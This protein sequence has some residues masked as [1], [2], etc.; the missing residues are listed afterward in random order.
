M[1]NQIIPLDLEESFKVEEYAIKMGIEP[2]TF[3]NDYM[4]NIQVFDRYLNKKNELLKGLF[5]DE[6]D[7]SS[8]TQSEV[9]GSK[10]CLDR[11]EK[12]KQLIN[13]LSFSNPKFKLNISKELKGREEIR[14]MLFDEI[15]KQ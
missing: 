2:L 6:L 7:Q 8:I 13:S 11:C 4:Q 9:N 12:N 1:G 3:T 14:L 5:I 10:S 15:E